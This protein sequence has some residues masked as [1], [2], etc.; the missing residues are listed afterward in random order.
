MQLLVKMEMEEEQRLKQIIPIQLTWFDRLANWRACQ[1]QVQQRAVNSLQSIT[2]WATRTSMVSSFKCHP[3]RP[4]WYERGLDICDLTCLSACLV[5]LLCIFFISRVSADHIIFSYQIY[6]LSWSR[7]A[8]AA[9][10][11]A[12]I[13]IWVRSFS[14]TSFLL[15]G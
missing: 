12:H 6:H 5:S 15:L 2:A 7:S 3:N 13:S 9:R 14:P 8:A 1:S 11:A 10:G 4:A